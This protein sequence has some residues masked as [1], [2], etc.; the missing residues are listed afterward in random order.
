[1]L[2]LVRP[3]LVVLAVALG[4]LGT[5]SARATSC[6][7]PELGPSAASADVVFVGTVVGERE[8]RIYTLNVSRVYK[9]QVTKTVKVLGGGMKGASF[10]VGK[11]FLVFARIQL[12]QSQ[13]VEAPLFAHLCGGTGLADQAKDW[14][15]K[16]GSGTEPGKDLVT[17]NAPAAPVAGAGSEAPAT[18]APEPAPTTAP[19]AQPPPTHE[20]PAPTTAPAPETR[21]PARAPPESGCAACNLGA[22]ASDTS[23][24]PWALVALW[25]VRRARNSKRRHDARGM[26]RA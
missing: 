13:P 18:P 1:M 3:L 17:G 6:A 19:S 16:L 24:E 11:R 5:S 22:P 9:G 23:L 2:R 21:A 20:A 7:V 4:L 8:H 15:A 12:A 26:L 14:I 10:E 25:A